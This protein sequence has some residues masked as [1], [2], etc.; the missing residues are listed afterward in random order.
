VG[1]F[2]F[3]TIESPSAYVSDTAE[4]TQSWTLTLVCGANTPRPRIGELWF[5]RLTTLTR[6]V[7]PDIDV[8]EGDIAQIRVQGAGGRQEVV[9]DL[10]FPVSYSRLKVRTFTDAQH[11]QYRNEIT[12]GTRFG[13][14]PIVVVPPDELQGSGRLIHARVG[15]VV[16]TKHRDQTWR[17]FD[18]DLMESPMARA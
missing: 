1:N 12:R 10:K 16:Q 8:T 7:D 9:S 4:I 14:D 3:A 11:I 17:E 5:G 2:T 6:G 18:V 15:A 13:A